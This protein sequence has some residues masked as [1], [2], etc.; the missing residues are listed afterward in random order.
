MQRSP[1]TGKRLLLVVEGTARGMVRAGWR[2]LPSIT[3]AGPALVTPIVEVALRL[4]LIARAAQA[5]LSWSDEEA[6]AMSR[7]ARC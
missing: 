7:S 3:D 5:L 1:A 4:L 2:S 6:A